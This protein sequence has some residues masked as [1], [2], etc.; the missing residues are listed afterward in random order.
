MADVGAGDESSVAG[1]A[2][3]VLPGSVPAYEEKTNRVVSR[4]ASVRVPAVAAVSGFRVG[5]GL[6]LDR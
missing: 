1:T 4:L 2:S 5:Q 6:G 3:R